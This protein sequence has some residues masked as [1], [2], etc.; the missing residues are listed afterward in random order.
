MAEKKG[1]GGYGSENYDPETGRYI[2]E[3]SSYHA[4]VNLSVNDL[5]DLLKQGYFDDP[6]LPDEEGL[7]SSIFA[8]DKDEEL[9]ED[10]DVWNLKNTVISA[11]QKALDDAN[12]KA[13]LLDTNYP[14]I[15]PA[16]FKEW[17]KQCQEATS[18]KDRAAF[19]NEYRGAG[20]LSFEFNKALRFGFDKFYQLYPRFLNSPSLNPQAIT[21][22]AQKLDNLTNSWSF[23]ENKKVIRSLDTAP[24]ISWFRD[25]GVFDGMA[26]Y[27]NQY[28]YDMLKPGYD[29]QE[30]VNR[31]NTL[32]GTRVPPD[33]SFTSFSCMSDASHMLKN[34]DNNN[35]D[36]IIRYNVRPGTKAWISDYGYESEGLFNRTTGFFIQGAS[37]EK[38]KDDRGRDWEVIVL[39]YGIQ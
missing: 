20:D 18:I 15:T 17:G 36:I 35:R 12:T 27:K 38:Y 32:V 29:K 2:K 33:G 7:Y 4:G 34:L 1:K 21:E 25:T 22:R 19:N 31:L 26:M 13:S 10:E 28:N 37:L 8:N 23:P 14:E 3:D 6:D 39:E 30:L 5:I 11:F 24:L 9:D 16:E